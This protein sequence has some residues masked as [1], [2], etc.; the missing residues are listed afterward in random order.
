MSNADGDIGQAPPG[1]GY[2]GPEP[3]PIPHPAAAAATKPIDAADRDDLLKATV[4]GDITDFEVGHEQRPTWVTMPDRCK[5]ML[6]LMACVLVTTTAVVMIIAVGQSPYCYDENDATLT[7]RM[8]MMSWMDPYANPCTDFYRYACGRYEI[9]YRDES[10]FGEAQNLVI[11]MLA[12]ASPATVTRLG[13]IYTDALARN[14]NTTNFELA[15]LF[16]GCVQAEVDADY[17]DATKAAVYLYTPC[18]GSCL[19]QRHSTAPIH[20]VSLVQVP[21]AVPAGIHDFLTTA[22]HRNVPVYWFPPNSNETSL[23][24]WYARHCTANNTETPVEM[25]Q[26]IITNT[27]AYSLG[28]TYYSHAL[29]NAALTSGA[30]AIQASD[31]VRLSITTIVETVK[32]LMVDYIDNGATFTRHS[33]RLK[34]VYKARIQSIEVEF[35][36]GRMIVPSCELAVDLYDCLVERWDAQNTLIEAS[37]ARPSVNISDQWGMCG[38]SVNAM[39][40][41]ISNR[42]YIPYALATLPFYSPLWPPSYQLASIGGVIAHEIGHGIRPG[43]NFNPGTGAEEMAEFE[44]CIIDDYN[45]SGSER[46]IR[47]LNEDFADAISLQTIIRAFRMQSARATEV[48]FILA[49]QT[50]CAAGQPKH[51]PESYL[52]PHAAPYLRV[53]S[54][55][56]GLLPFYTVFE[57]EPPSSRVIC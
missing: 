29:T 12:A 44:S 31:G 52:D 27:S 13:T 34:N 28:F 45:S 30:L 36:H 14:T 6:L 32:E 53:N 21:P 7:R 57:C 25:W 15:G 22:F 18:D 35:G 41:P 26:G 1:G 40:N 2:Y 54:T 20:I 3:D 47:T 10:V 43:W 24:E 23:P 38:L 4:N 8:Q 16:G 39:Y 37:G 56:K 33:S 19:P 9:Q 5:T 48:G 51:Y 17:R 50:W 42:V 46:P 55:V 49:A 11:G